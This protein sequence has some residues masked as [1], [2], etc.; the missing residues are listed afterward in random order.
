MT[1]EQARQL[2]PL[3]LAYMGDAIY[4]MYVRQSLIG[5]HPGRTTHDLHIMATRLVRAG[6]QAFT[7]AALMDRLTEEE[8]GVFRRGRNMHNATVPNHADVGD[9]RAS[10]GFEA[11][12]FGKPAEFWAAFEAVLG[13]LYLTEQTDRLEAVL[14][15]ASQMTWEELER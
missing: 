10:T 7:A 8:R 1:N 4:E 5:R 6:A 13:Y 2:S 15:M 9:Y 14:A 3:T 12:G 11:V